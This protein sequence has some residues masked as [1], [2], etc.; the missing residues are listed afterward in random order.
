MYKHRSFQEL[1]NAV[2]IRIKTAFLHGFTEL[3][4]CCDK[5]YK[6]GER[7]VRGRGREGA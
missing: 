3:D 5:K 2:S 6:R 4:K 1:K 7:D